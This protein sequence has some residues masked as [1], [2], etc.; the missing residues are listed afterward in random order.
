MGGVERSISGKYCA[1]AGIL[2]MR[3]TCLVRSKRSGGASI[4]VP[5]LVTVAVCWRRWSHGSHSESGN[6]NR[7]RDGDGKG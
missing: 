1:M 7:V 3:A 6:S 2:A 5:R 4:A